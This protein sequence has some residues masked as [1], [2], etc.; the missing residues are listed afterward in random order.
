[1][2]EYMHKAYTLVT[3]AVSLISNLF[4]LIRRKEV[5]EELKVGN[6]F[7]TNNVKCIKVIKSATQ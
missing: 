3:A 5:A 7:G 1:M 4:V 2:D 6:L